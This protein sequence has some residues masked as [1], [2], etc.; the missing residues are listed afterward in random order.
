[1]AK[2]LALGT[3]EYYSNRQ[4][5]FDHVVRRMCQVLLGSEVPFRRLERRMAEQ[6]LGSVPVLH[7]TAQLR[8]RSSEVVR[9]EVRQPAT[10]IY[11]FRICPR[12]PIPKGRNEI[13]VCAGRNAQD[14]ND[15][16]SSTTTSL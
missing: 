7:G 11:V 5:Q 15:V 12:L 14:T 1:M 4:P 9:G 2:P 16:G 13:A 6:L 10:E 8:R 3:K